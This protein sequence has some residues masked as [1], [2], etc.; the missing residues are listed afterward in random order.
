[1][2]VCATPNKLLTRYS[3]TDGESFQ[4]RTAVVKHKTIKSTPTPN[5]L[6]LVAL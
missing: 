4:A 6:L 2:A 3:K 5:D 1:M